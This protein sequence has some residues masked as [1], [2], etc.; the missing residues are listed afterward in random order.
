M[1][2]LVAAFGQSGVGRL[3]VA[4]GGCWSESGEDRLADELAALASAVASVSV[5]EPEH[6]DAL[7]G[8]SRVS[9]RLEA[10][11]LCVREDRVVAP[12]GAG[13]QAAR[14]MNI[15]GG[16]AMASR[17]RLAVCISDHQGKSAAIAAALADAGHFLVGDPSL[18]DAVLI[19]HDVPFH[20]KLP[21]VEACVAAGGRAFL[22]PHG[23]DSGLMAHWDGLYPPSPLLSGVLVA[24]PGYAEIAR[25]YEYPAPVH[26]IGWS[27]CP[28]AERRVG[29][30]PRRVVFAPTHPPYL[31]NPRYPAR[32]REVF[33]R[34]RALDYELTVRHLG[35]LEA[36]GLE[37]VPGVAYVQGDLPGAPGMLE[38]I[39]ATDCVVGDR[40]TFS[41]L[42]I[43]RGVT[44][45][46]WDAAII[47][48][49]SGTRFPIHLDRYLDY[50]RYPFDVDDR[51]DLAATIAAAAADTE[52]VADWRARFIGDPLDPSAL[53]RVIA[54][55]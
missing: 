31:G 53:E 49:N 41:N 54:G 9:H 18:A 45:V 35:P 2:D 39:D 55:D 5:L 11:G 52:L 12:C 36:N 17:E 47:E 20:G 40:G 7:A 10:G 13:W 19:D 1:A 14:I 27:L 22:Y 51:D 15:D 3:L 50:L 30:V 44:T 24:A 37:P 8:L 21:L 4:Y 34:L 25:R 32:N 42:A 43:A 23:A 28:L 16:V 29:I 38:Q 6:P 46:V 33:D 48:D 26:V